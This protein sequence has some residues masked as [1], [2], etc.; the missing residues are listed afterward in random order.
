MVQSNRPCKAKDEPADHFLI[1]LF[2]ALYFKKTVLYT[3]I[4][5]TVLWSDSPKG[6]LLMDLINAPLTE[7]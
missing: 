3:R 5:N 2:T 7:P 4:K 6:G 1:D